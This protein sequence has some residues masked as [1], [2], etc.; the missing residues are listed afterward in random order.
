[1]PSFV[2]TKPS[3]S[4]RPMKHVTRVVQPGTSHVMRPTSFRLQQTTFDAFRVAG[5]ASSL[6]NPRTEEPQV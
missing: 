6:V 5:T 2:M 1:M 4:A 3:P